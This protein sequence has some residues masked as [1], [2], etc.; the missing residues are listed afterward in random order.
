MTGILAVCYLYL[1]PLW[2]LF[3]QQT[4]RR[5]AGKED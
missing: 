3:V 5:K 1:V 2:N 4:A